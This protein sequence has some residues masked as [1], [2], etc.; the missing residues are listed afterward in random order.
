MR[1]HNLS[2]DEAH[3]TMSIHRPQR[4]HTLSAVLMLGASLLSGLPA[5]AQ[6][7]SWQ[8]SPTNSSGAVVGTVTWNGVAVSA[9]DWIGAFDATGN[10]AGATQIILNAGASY[11][12]LPVYGDDGTTPSIDEGIT[13]NEAFT[14][15]LWTAG[16]EVDY[17]DEFGD[18]IWLAEWVNANGAPMPAYAD[19]AA[20]Y[21]FE[22]DFVVTIECP[23]SPVCIESA[24]VP[25][26]GQPAGG[27]FSGN[28]VVEEQ[29]DPWVAGIGQHDIAYEAAGLLATCVIEV[30]G[31]PSAVV[32]SE[33]Q[34]CANDAPAT[35]QAESSGG[36]WSG[37]GVFG[38]VFDPSVV[39]PGTS[40]V[41]YEVT[42]GGCTA[43]SETAFTVYPAPIQPQIIPL[44][45]GGYL[46]SGAAWSNVSWWINGIESLEWTNFTEI[47][48]ITGAST[49]QVSVTNAYGCSATSD[50][51]QVVGVTNLKPTP[52]ERPLHF[53]VLGQRCNPNLRMPSVFGVQ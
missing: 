17:T 14:L 16:M 51:L 50:E 12:N 31:A 44:A 9:D 27:T 5:F 40:W 13:G 6:P 19:A 53:N 24:P 33:T 8:V 18:I 35:L 46:A 23:A 47:P 42:S 30:V 37:A 2:S 34:F 45:N 21:N 29:F 28:G 26:A 22:S 3:N 52:V 10:C 15:R 20:V 1:C 32:V 7:S 4:T 48:A 39:M 25:L 41:G 36:I 11:F 38:D 43:E 49:I